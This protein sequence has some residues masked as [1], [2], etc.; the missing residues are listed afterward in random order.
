MPLHFNLLFARR[1]PAALVLVA[2]HS[3]A[4]NAQALT[5]TCHEQKS[6]AAPNMTFSYNGAETGTLAV[7][8]PFG[9]ISLPATRQ[10]QEQ[11]VDGHST[12]VTGIQAFGHAEVLVPDR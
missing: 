6:D 10:E 7:S 1:L 9:E 4:A 12:T 5:L 11:V 2:L 3:G 8:A